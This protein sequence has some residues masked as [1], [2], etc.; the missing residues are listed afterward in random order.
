MRLSFRILLGAVL[1]LAPGLLVQ[2]QAPPSAPRLTAPRTIPEPANVQYDGSYYVSQ[3]AGVPET[4][5]PSR[6]AT[7]AWQP[8]DRPL[9]VEVNVVQGAEQKD[10]DLKK[11]VDLLKEQMK[12][13]QQEI[14]LLKEQVQKQPPAGAVVEKLQF[15]AATLEAR[16]LQAAR[17]DQEAAMGLDNIAEH[18][19]AVERNGPRLPAPLKELFL[20]SGTNETPLS[21]Y[22]T[23]VGGAQVFPHR[24]GEGQLFF[25]AIE[26]F[27]LLQLNDHMLLE[28]E[29]E[30]STSDVKVSQAQIDF[31]V[32]DWLAVVAGRFINPVGY[33]G[34]RLH[35]DWINKMP[36]FPLSE[37]QVAL[38]EASF[39]G[40][41]LRGGAYLCCSPVKMEY[42]LFVANGLGL[43]ATND[44]TGVA[45]LDE[46]VDTN[47]GVNDAL[48]WGG[49]VGVLVPEWGINVGVS[50]FF[51]R[52]Y[53]ELSGPDINLWDF[54]I[55]FHRGNW[56]VRF[57]YADTFQRFPLQPPA[58]ADQG[59]QAAE[60]PPPPTNQHIRRRGFYAQVAYRPNDSS[61][62]FLRNLEGVFR[63]SQARFHGIDPTTLDLT[64]FDSPVAAPVDRDQ[65][66]FGVNYY[67]YSSLVMKVAYEINHERG[68]DLKDNVLL[69]QLAWGF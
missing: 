14:K 46:L 63:Y 4:A 36:D 44:A 29:L 2:G 12:L 57:E 27:I 47:R 6:T 9:G 61:N 66:T 35:P 39:N 5:P 13:Q 42:A 21:I 17:R 19:D 20:P 60:G 51:N 37:R 48:A 8:D 68:T 22:G 18:L 50:T 69:V 34:E 62:F 23:F 49:R 41:Q 10:E 54:D 45:N 31:I 3:P 15:Q 1:T 30:F 40:V 55:N 11:Q 32:N 65:Y 56:D 64:R 58:A 24:T 43:P 59:D 25:D 33:F 26:P 52:P 28:S 7:P 16:S 38:G 53:G 67:F